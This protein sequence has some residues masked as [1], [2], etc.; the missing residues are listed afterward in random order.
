MHASSRASPP[1]GP[2]AHCVVSVGLRAKFCREW[3]GE[4]ELL[5]NF[6]SVLLSLPDTHS[7]ACL[8]FSFCLVY[9]CAPHSYILQVT[10]PQRYVNSGISFLTYVASLRGLWAGLPRDQGSIPGMGKR[11]SSFFTAPRSAHEASSC[12]GV[13]RPWRETDRSPSPSAQVNNT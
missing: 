11:C 9:L 5:F 12:W 10:P 2:F 4:R 7:R 6:I 8:C 13:R 3:D 1:C